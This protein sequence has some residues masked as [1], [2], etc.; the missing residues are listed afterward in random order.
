MKYRWEVIN[1]LITKKGYESYLEVGVK[2]G[3]CY[4]RV[5]C[6]EKKGI[7]IDL[8]TD[9]DGTVQ[10]SSDDFFTGPKR[11]ECFDIIFIDGDH[12]EKQVLTDITN[13]LG[14]LSEDG[15]IVMHDCNPKKAVYATPERGEN[16]P[17]WSGTAYRAYLRFKEVDERLSMCVVD[18]DWGCGVITF[19][20]QELIDLPENYVWEDFDKNRVEWLNLI[21]VEEFK[22]R[23]Q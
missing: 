9:S 12:H 16:Q 19:G 1:W 10:I 15:A 20:R 3:Y 4:D 14:A 11:Q 17:L 23:F 6:V 18:V 8:K 13:A 5:K 2:D 7:D 22:R 21:S